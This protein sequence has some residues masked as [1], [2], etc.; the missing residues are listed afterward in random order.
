MTLFSARQGLPGCALI[1]ALFAL[2]ACS[3]GEGVPRCDGACESGQFCEPESGLCIPRPDTDDGNANISPYFDAYMS[4]GRF[5]V[6]VFDRLWGRFLYGEQESPGA[7]F[8]WE[9]IAV[10]PGE[11]PLFVPRLTLLQ[12]P[13]Q[14]KVLMEM[15]AGS[16][17]L[18]GQT[19][20]GWL[21]EEL[22]TL[23]SPLTHLHGFWDLEAG[24]HICVGDG[25]GKLL[26]AS[27]LDQVPFDPTLVELAD[28]LGTPA[29]PC[30]VAL[31]GGKKTI[32]SAARPAGLL[33]ISW[34][35]ESGWTGTVIDEDAVVGALA[36]RHTAYGLVIAYLDIAT[37]ALK[38]AT[39]ESGLVSVF[40]ADPGAMLPAD[41]GPQ[42]P[43]GLSL[44]SDAGSGKVYLSYHNRIEDVLYVRD[45]EASGT[46]G[47]FAELPSAALHFPALGI[48]QSGHPALAAV[49]FS[50]PGTLDAGSFN[51]LSI[52]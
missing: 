46:W 21:L 15:G 8:T 37:G 12:S 14:P 3:A 43:F 17:Y 1:G 28:D 45:L 29:A 16:L 6:V 13:G 38:Y 30:V 19:A 27:S 4:E 31:L 25:N 42:L 9:T 48:D 33:S 11:D 32:L 10:L 52:R 20:S 39:S 24:A 5:H 49:Q 34:K 26:Y 47:T 35:Q 7:D 51:I 23:P 36:H 2:V 44:A 40:V 22:F 50:P 41:S 18:A